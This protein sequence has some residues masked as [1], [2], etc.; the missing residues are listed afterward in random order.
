MQTI[1]SEISGSKKFFLASKIS[2]SLIVIFIFGGN[3]MAQNKCPAIAIFTVYKLLLKDGEV[4]RHPVL[5]INFK[6]QNDRFIELLYEKEYLQL[7]M[8]Y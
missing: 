7:A 3:C 4:M 2:F 8:N 6:G 5:N 1:L